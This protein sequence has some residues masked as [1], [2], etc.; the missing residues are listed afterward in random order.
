MLMLA[1][2]LL[3]WQAS[4]AAL[5]PS[6]DPFL[7][8]FIAIIIIIRP[9]IVRYRATAFGPSTSSWSASRPIVG[10]V[11]SY[12][13]STRTVGAIARMTWHLARTSALNTTVSTVI[14]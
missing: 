13:A 8:N 9:S 12:A 2:P 11:W 6:L 10:M 5:N 14:K 3:K 4:L 7:T 1:P